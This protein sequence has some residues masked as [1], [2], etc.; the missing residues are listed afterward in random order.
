MLL[1]MGMMLIV[2]I[3]L[4]ARRNKKMQEQLR[5]RQDTMTRGTKVMTNF[6]LYGTV[7]T[8]NRD[9]NTAHLQ[10]APGTIVKV[11]L[12]TVTTIEDEP[13]AGN[14]P[15]INGDVADEPKN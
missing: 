1:L 8:I 10:I 13:A 4:P 15:T 6:G 7:D 9:D 3:V 11:H 12:A 2:L 14:Q 5:Q